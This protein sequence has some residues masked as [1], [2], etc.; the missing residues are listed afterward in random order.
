MFIERINKEYTANIQTALSPLQF[1]NASSFQS[2]PQMT[3]MM[4]YFR[5]IPDW[6]SV[7]KIK[8]TAGK[9]VPRNDL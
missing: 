3:P 8:S 9:L 4:C 5:A 2:L 7:Q 6:V 1:C